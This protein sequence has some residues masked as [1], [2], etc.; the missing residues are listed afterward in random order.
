MKIF[1]SSSAL[2][3]WRREL[4]GRKIGFVPT[5]GALHEGHA[6]LLER[7]RSECDVVVLSIFVN[8]TQFNQT[9]DFEKYPKSWEADLKI[10][11]E[12]MVDAIFFPKDQSEI[13]P[14]GFQY[15]ITEKQLSKTLCG[16]FRP[17]HFD[18]VLTVVMKLFQLVKPT[19]AYF[20]EK[21]FQQLALIE[22]MV[23]AFFLDVLIIPCPT[24]RET[25]GLALSSRNQRLNADDKA[26]A[27]KLHQIIMQFEDIR[28]ASRE[29]D[30]AGFKVEYLV[31]QQIAG[32]SRRLVAA[33]LGEVRLIDNVAH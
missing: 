10:A 3:S 25:S 23:K 14:D 12:Q 21:D 32:K 30:E 17:G 2:Q 33:W 19:R 11:Q 9:S 29:L 15:Q 27:P 20:G 26:L 18:G 13:Y 1:E 22:G 24:I 31:D 5:M 16:E 6:S 4:T 8:P 28:D 7:A